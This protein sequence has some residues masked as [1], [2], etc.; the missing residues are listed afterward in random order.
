MT[1]PWP[2]S[3]PSSRMSACTPPRTLSKVSSETV[4]KAASI[5]PRMA[6][7]APASR[8]AVWA[9]RSSVMSVRGRDHAVLVPGVVEVGVDLPQPGELEPCAQLGEGEGAERDRVLAGQ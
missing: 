7:L 1:L 8:S 2:I 3:S 9:V 5:R 4:P 6:D